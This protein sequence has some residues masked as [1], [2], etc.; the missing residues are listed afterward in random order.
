MEKKLKIDPENKAILDLYAKT[1]NAYGRY[2]MSQKEIKLAKIS[3]KRAYAI[4]VKLNGETFENNV[5]FLNLLGTLYHAGGNFHKAV[6]YFRKAK[7]IGQHLHDMKSFAVVYINLA[8]TYFKLGMLEKAEKSCEKALQNAKIHSN[9]RAK[10]EA[11][12]GLARVNNAMKKR[13]IGN[14]RK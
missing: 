7:K 9:F 3:F 11:E 12:I 5:I 10:K 4:N 14:V 13:R 1:L 2:L 8:D 6:L